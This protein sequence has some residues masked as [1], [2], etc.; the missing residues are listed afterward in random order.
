M[1]K[2]K[3]TYLINLVLAIVLIPASF[4]HAWTGLGQPIGSDKMV[5]TDAVPYGAFFLIW[6]VIFIGLIYYGLSLLQM[7]RKE[8]RKVAEHSSIAF[9]LCIVWAIL[10]QVW[11]PRLAWFSPLILVGSYGAAMSAYLKGIKVVH[12]VKKPLYWKVTAPLGLFAGW[13]GLA[14]FINLSVVLESSG[15]SL[16]RLN[17][18]DQSAFLIFGATLLSLFMV[19]RAK[20]EL[21]YP[22]AVAWGLLGIFFAHF[23]TLAGDAALL[24]LLVL[25]LGTAILHYVD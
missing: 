20:A 13:L 24:S 17:R 2:L 10:A 22:V 8:F 23:S 19:Y 11:G 5:V 6:W 9:G 14:F 21:S 25:V 1:Q 12:R 15:V 16:L 3:S 7:K 4:L 18:G